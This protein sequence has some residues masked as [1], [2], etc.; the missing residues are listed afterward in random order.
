MPP[1]L[2]AGLLERVLRVL[3]AAE[4]PVRVRRELAVERL[5]ERAKRRLVPGFRGEHARGFAFFVRD[6]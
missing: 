6:R 4:H 3:V 2:E 5:D 1:R